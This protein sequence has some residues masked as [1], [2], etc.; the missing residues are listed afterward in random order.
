MT[1][2]DAQAADAGTATTDARPGPGTRPAARGGTWVVAL[3]GSPASIRALD[4]AVD[5]AAGTGGAVVAVYVVK[6]ISVTGEIIGASAATEQAA[7]EVTAELQILLDARA[8]ASGVGIRLEVSRGSVLTELVRAA[9][10]LNARGVLVGASGHRLIGA[11]APRIVHA[12]RW[13]VTVVP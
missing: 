3:D 10:T 1:T 9:D 13:P 4:L 12:G 11:L 2:E 5:T 7:D 6:R 8:A